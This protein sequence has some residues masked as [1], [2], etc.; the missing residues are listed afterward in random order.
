MPTNSTYAAIP[1]PTGTETSWGP[2]PFAALVAAIDTA[3][4]LKATS[5]SDRD[6]RF[7]GVDNGT[8]VSCAALNIL[9]Q[10]DSATSGGWNVLAETGVPVTTG[11]ITANTTGGWAVS[12]QWAQRLNG[13]VDLYASLTYSGSTLTGGSVTSTQPGSLTDVEMCTLQSGY[14]IKSGF[15][16]WIFPLTAG[17]NGGAA[18]TGQINV[19]SQ[20]IF[21][22]TIAPS[23]TVQ[24]GDSVEFAVTY[25]GV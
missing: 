20:K 19:A 10:R 22:S 18:G 15:T 11:A 2:T 23:A 8:L 7:A 25:P 24:S 12:S 1:I 17:G 14:L 4:V 9:W 6:T 3:V 16:R 21:L 5:Q 13:R